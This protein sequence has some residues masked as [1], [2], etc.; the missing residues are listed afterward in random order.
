LPAAR[1]EP[2]AGSA[3]VVRAGLGASYASLNAGHERLGGSAFLDLQASQRVLALR[4]ALR[5][6]AQASRTIA[7]EAETELRILTG[8]LDL[9]PAT[10]AFGGVEARP[11]AAAELGQIT[12]ERQVRGGARDSA[13]WSAL[14]AEV[15]LLW[16]ASGR[17]ALE[18]EL[19]V[20]IPLTRY[21]FTLDGGDNVGRTGELAAIV[22]IG[23]S[24]RLQ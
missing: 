14:L 7:S 20:S 3:A 9:C 21:D 13:L 1:R 23:G 16:P 22:G 18:L 5:V 10:V 2:V 19:G 12:A 8:R 17:W 4:P 6:S 24:F 15:R 11:C